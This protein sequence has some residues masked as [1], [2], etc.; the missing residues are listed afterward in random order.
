MESSSIRGTIFGQALGDAIGLSTEYMELSEIKTKYYDNNIKLDDTF[1]FEK[2]V[3]DYHRSTWRQGDWTDDTDLLVLGIK[4]YIEAN[5]KANAYL[6]RK[7]LDEWYKNGIP[8]CDD[9]KP[10][11][12][13]YT[14]GMIWGDPFFLDNDISLA[15]RRAYLYNPSF[16]CSIRSNGGVMRTSWIGA[17]HYENIDMLAEN[18]IENCIVTH[19]DPYCVGSALF[20]NLLIAEIINSTTGIFDL[21]I[22]IQNTIQNTRK[23][24]AEYIHIFNI[25][26]IRDIN[27]LKE[28]DPFYNVIRDNYK[29]FKIYHVENI[30]DDIKFYI[31]KKSL[32]D[33]KINENISYTNLPIGIA[34][35]S[36]KK[37]INN[38]AS[39]MDVIMDI[40]K[41]G[42]DA[43]T[44][45]AITG[46]VCGAFIG[47]DKLPQHLIKKMPY[48]KYLMN[49]VEKICD[50]KFAN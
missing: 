40:V 43:D 1:T 36:L 42:G 14:I 23:Y 19:C 34:V 24:L 7:E 16:P 18:T 30:I 28:T 10:H 11:G 20:I 15:A 12:C 29:Y 46:A 21:N 48:E 33:L 3:Q 37:I 4:S 39:F 32:S 27:N 13:G 44:N 6:F 49:L 25:R 47:F 38:K 45:C 5:G 35:I 31:N 22:A 41:M 50:L 9:T 17:T 2:I 8:E 26:I